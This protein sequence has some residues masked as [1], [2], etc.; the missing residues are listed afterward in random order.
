M[1]LVCLF[2][3]ITTLAPAQGPPNEEFTQSPNEHFIDRQEQ[4]F[5]VRVVQGVITRETESD[6]PL[7]DVVF[8][9]RGSGTHGRVKR[10]VTDEHGR[11]KIGG[12]PDGTYEFKAT[13]SGFQ[14]IMGTIVV[15]KK[16]SK[17][18]QIKIGMLL[19]V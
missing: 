2:L 10:A 11:F 18:D 3:A 17:Q 9:I 8:E 4:P 7:R 15:S 14:S 12:V 13:L 16:K 6:G 5:E 1:K 19:G